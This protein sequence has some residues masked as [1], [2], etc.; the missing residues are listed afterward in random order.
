MVADDPNKL[1]HAFLKRQNKMCSNKFKNM[2]IV[3]ALDSM[4]HQKVVIFV[5]PLKWYLNVA[6]GTCP[7]QPGERLPL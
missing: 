7:S 3:I 1:I 6:K 4:K 2:Q 5:I